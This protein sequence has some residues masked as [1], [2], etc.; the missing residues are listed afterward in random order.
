M[1]KKNE[2]LEKIQQQ[3]SSVNLS[4]KV[5]KAT[6]IE[7]SDI[8]SKKYANEPL[9]IAKKASDVDKHIYEIAKALSDDKKPNERAETLSDV[10]RKIKE[11][12]GIVQKISEKKDKFSSPLPSDERLIPENIKRQIESNRENEEIAEYA[13]KFDTEQ[14]EIIKKEKSLKK[15]KS[16]FPSDAVYDKSGKATDLSGKPYKFKKLKSI[17]GILP[18]AAATALSAYSPESK[19]ASIAKTVSRVADEGD[20]IS[21]LFPEGA[22]EGEDKE[23]MRMREEQKNKY[24]DN[25]MKSG[26]R[27]RNEK[28]RT[29]AKV[30]TEVEPII[31]ILGGEPDIRPSKADKLT[32]EQSS[33]DL[34]EME[35]SLNYEDYLKKK[36]RQLGY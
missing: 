17:L 36:K 1:K 4:S 5:K 27:A 14:A 21:F 33:P 22:G 10:T 24:F 35:D 15:P 29:E 30:K 7:P 20:P 11:K 3:P 2:M 25:L 13:K 16:E 28:L 31:K 23:V 26:N 34:E 32:G 9:E 8:I 12:G 18:A 19:A 6:A